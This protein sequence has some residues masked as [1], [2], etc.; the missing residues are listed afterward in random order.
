MATTRNVQREL[1]NLRK[2]IAGLQQ[3]YS[4][5]KGRARATKTEGLERFGAIRDDLVDTID[6]IK[7]KVTNGT[8]AA[9][10]EISAHIDDL[11]NLV[12]DYSERTEKTVAAHPIAALA[13]ALAI[14]WLIGRLNRSE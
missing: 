4:R 12:G 1:D 9:A 8:G 5:L 6:A 10:D 14:G 7:A 3:D 13:G 11:R 2:E